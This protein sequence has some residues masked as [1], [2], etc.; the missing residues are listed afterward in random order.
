MLFSRKTPSLKTKHIIAIA[1]LLPLF[2]V[3]LWWV[4]SYT[5]LTLNIGGQEIVLPLPSDIYAS[6]LQL[7]AYEPRTTLFEPLYNEL[8]AQRQSIIAQRRQSQ[9]D[10]VESYFRQYGSPLVGLGH[11][12]VDKSEEC[13]GDYRVL[14]GIAG[15][16]SG[17]GRINVLKYN[18]FGYLNG[19][20]YESQQQALEILSCIVSQQHISKCGIDLNCLVKRYAGPQDDPQLFINK[21]AFFM[22]QVD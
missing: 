15:S 14:V 3:Y 11:I 6:E 7:P 18:P 16:E 22:R 19:V 4:S 12:F 1:F 13:G 2:I 8:E 17:L 10:K 21:V 9:I 5:N 20:Q